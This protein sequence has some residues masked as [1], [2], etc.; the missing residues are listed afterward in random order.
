MNRAKANRLVRGDGA[1]H[2]NLLDEPADVAMDSDEGSA[3]LPPPAR[4]RGRGGRGRGGRG[5]GRGEWLYYLS[6]LAE[7]ML[8]PNNKHRCAVTV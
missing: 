4:G 3:P 5:R 8:T 2:L 1:A 7:S 6:R